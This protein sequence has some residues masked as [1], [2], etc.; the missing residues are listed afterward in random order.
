MIAMRYGSGGDLSK[1]TGAIIDLLWTNSDPTS[2]FSAQTVSID[3]SSYSHAIIVGSLTT[4]STSAKVSTF[5]KIGDKFALCGIAAATSGNRFA[6][7][8]DVTSSGVDF[9]TGYQN[10]TAGTGYMIP[11]EIYGVKL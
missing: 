2:N 8:A 7:N 11:Q 1:R 10:T 3:L 9:T 5:G 4:S 6:R